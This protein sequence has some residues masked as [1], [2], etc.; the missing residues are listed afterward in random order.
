MQTATLSQPKANPRSYH[1]LTHPPN[2]LFLIHT[3]TS[4]HTPTSAS[5]TPP[6]KQ[7]A[8]ARTKKK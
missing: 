5:R 4:T 1:T 6:T 7:T 2:Q 3:L 8:P